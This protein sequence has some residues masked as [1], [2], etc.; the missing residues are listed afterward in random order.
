MVDFLGSKLIVTNSCMRPVKVRAETGS[1]TETK[2]GTRK[3]L[4]SSN[5]TDFNHQVDSDERYQVG[6]GFYQIQPDLHQKCVG[7]ERKS[8]EKVEDEYRDQYA[9]PQVVEKKYVLIQ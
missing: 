5:P 8:G 1:Q 2:D 3:V 7:H 9:P 6:L 4:L